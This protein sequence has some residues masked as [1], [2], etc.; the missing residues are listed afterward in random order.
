MNPSQCA[1]NAA[2]PLFTPNRLQTDSKQTRLPRTERRLHS[3]ISGHPI[4]TH[5]T[6]WAPPLPSSPIELRSSKPANH[7]MS[8]HR[9]ADQTFRRNSRY[10]SC[11]LPAR[12]LYQIGTRPPNTRQPEG[13]EFLERL[14]WC[15]TPQGFC[16]PNHIRVFVVKSHVWR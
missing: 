8:N 9:A 13:G 4:E 5:L 15:T 10:G 7:R 12:R 6:G 2:Y 3:K 11:S 14:R 1:P 16:L